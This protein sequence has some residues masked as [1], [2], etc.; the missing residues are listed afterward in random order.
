MSQHPI[1]TLS[2]RSV[3]QNKWLTLRE[4]KIQRQSGRDGLYTVV[5]KP[6]FAIIIPVHEGMVTMVEQFRYP[7]GE[8]QLEFPQGA[9]EEKPDARP[10]DLAAGE[11]KE[12]T[13]L[14]AGTL[15]HVAFQYLAYGFCN[16]GYHIFVAN[17]LTQ[18]AREPDQEEEDL[19]VHQ[20]AVDELERM[21]LDG[22]VK[23]ATTCN[24][25]G[26]ARLRGLI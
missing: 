1:R 12:E 26:Q 4:D 10:E 25:F 16:Q 24:A 18:H 22:S 19:I 23:D 14:V 8:R 15:T 3:Y 21:I 7:I 20:V 11:L 6:D 13:G 9:W 2:S 17:E 5:E